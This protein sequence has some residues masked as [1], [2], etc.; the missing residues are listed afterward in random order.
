MNPRTLLQTLTII[1][2][3]LIFAGIAAAAPKHET[4]RS[5]RV[6][7]AQASS[8]TIQSIDTSTNGPTQIQ[9][10][11]TFE[12]QQENTDALT[13]TPSAFRAKKVVSTSVANFGTPSRRAQ[14][15]RKGRIQ[16]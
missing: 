8:T 1:V 3:T 16:G 15:R 10:G 14:L 11:Y 5:N 4:N 7:N 13:A 9:A 2:I 12:I 6:S